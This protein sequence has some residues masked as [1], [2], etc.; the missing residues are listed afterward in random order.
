MKIRK[1]EINEGYNAM[2][3]INTL[4]NIFIGSF[5]GVFIGRS[6]HAYWF[7]KTHPDIYAHFS[8]PWYTDIIL[9]GATSSVIIIVLLIAKF[10][11]KRK[12]RK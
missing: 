12:M 4:L 2:K 7:Y 3:Q 5:I 11:V 1:F 8:A 6:L 9:Y 10:F